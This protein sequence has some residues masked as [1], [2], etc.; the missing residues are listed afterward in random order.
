MNILRRC[1]VALFLASGLF[2]SE[3]RAED[4]AQVLSY[5]NRTLVV[6]WKYIRPSYGMP[7][8]SGGS[9]FDPP[10]FGREPA[11]S[12]PATPEKAPTELDVLI[13]FGENDVVS[14]GKVPYAS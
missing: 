1:V 5:R 13:E 11:Q 8:R 12:T 10:L 2:V 6:T 7:S 9:D 3:S 14:L 4:G